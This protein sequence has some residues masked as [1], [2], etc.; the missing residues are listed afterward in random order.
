MVEPLLVSIR[1][2]IIEGKPLPDL[3]RACIFLGSE[4]GS[5]KLRQWAKYELDGYPPGAKLPDYR[6]LRPVH[7]QV[8]VRNGMQNIQGV[9]FA[10]WNFPENAREFYPTS[11]TLD[12]PISELIELGEQ[13]VSRFVNGDLLA[14]KDKFNV[15][16]WPSAEIYSINI[17][18]VSSFFVGL[19]DRVRN[20]LTSM[21]A[22]MT[23][24]DPLKSLPT[25]DQVDRV[26]MNN[27]EHNYETRIG[28][29]SGPVAV[30]A[31]AHA[32]QQGSS[33]A[34]V[35]KLIAELKEYGSLLPGDNGKEVEK[36]SSELENAFKAK[37]IDKPQVV[38]SVSKLQSIAAGLGLTGLNAIIEGIAQQLTELG[39]T[40]IFGV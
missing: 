18:L 35:L 19:V 31:G 37:E 26:V 40:G 2:G 3:L 16:H 29:V 28:N 27:V 12:Q 15:D 6:I 34:E 22:D 36:I 24:E 39:V 1:N 32:S 25:K 13:E 5:E 23:W 11:L 7:V 33:I 30:G 14:L 10:P 4:T 21:I 9:Q 38:R 17:S 8:S 20:L